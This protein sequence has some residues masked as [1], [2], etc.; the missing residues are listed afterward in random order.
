M[1]ERYPLIKFV[2]IFIAGMLIQSY[3]S[4]SLTYLILITVPLLLALI[5]FHYRGY[6]KGKYVLSFILP[7]FIGASL[8]GVDNSNKPVYPFAKDKITKANVYG[9]ITEMS[10][11]AK[12]K[13]TFTIV[14]DSVLIDDTLDE[15]AARLLCKVSDINTTA[16]KQ[17]YGRL[18][19]GNRVRVTGTIQKGRGERNPG[20]FNYREYLVRKGY[21][22][23]LSVYDTDNVKL[24]TTDTHTFA[25]TVFSI[26]KAIDE[27]I[28]KLYGDDAAPL[29]RSLLLADRSEL[30]YEVREHFVNAGVVHVLA[31]SGLHVGFIAFVLYV[32]TARFNVYVRYGLTI[33]GILA[34]L[35]LTGFH[36]SVFRASVMAIVYIA[37]L[38]SNRSTNGYNSLALAALII[39]IINPNELFE[40]G[41]QLSFSAV[42]A[43]LA[44]YPLFSKWIY[45]LGVKAKIIRWLLLF[46]A[47]SL[48]AQLGT[49]PFTLIY[50]N[51]LSLVSLAANVF[52]VPAVAAIV[53]LGIVTL[54]LSTVWMWLA[55]IYAVTNMLLIDAMLWLIKQAGTASFSHIPV[56][57]FSF[58]DTLVFYILLSL[59]LYCFAKFGSRA[60]KAA[61]A[62]LIIA[63]LFV[64]MSIDNRDILSGDKLSVLTIDVGQGDAQLIKFPGGKT[65]LID[66]GNANMFYDTGER[67]IIPL[68]KQLEIDRLDYAVI[69]NYKSDH[70]KGIYSLIENGYVDSLFIPEGNEELRSKLQEYGVHYGTTNIGRKEIANAGVYFLT[71][72][73]EEN[74]VLKLVYGST[75]FLFTSDIKTRDEA[76]LALRY[77][78]F[79]NANYIKAAA[80]GSRTSTSSLFLTA[81]KPEYA[82]ISC[83]YMNRFGH[84]DEE[85]IERLNDRNITIYR[86]DSEGAVLFHSDGERIEYSDWRN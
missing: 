84:P 57:N 20:E 60:A 70:Y 78:N 10:L 53:S 55:G 56:Y 6:A 82:I 2:I 12:N 59:L 46:M 1:I 38:L 24:L 17:L 72:G 13:I 83:G 54:A 73:G 47:V 34:F 48:A 26:R 42:L 68:L 9:T 39:L 43:I 30:S 32:L 44:L 7:L 19:V 52:V 36:A 27:R 23:L 31:V 37:A 3:F 76:D 75:S 16:R 40:P 14:T 8:L 49:L 85:V 69:T 58:Y 67:T 22:G 50:F 74:Q 21:S 80:H 5:L 77:G 65:M 11:L 62:V 45:Q 41:F 25:N 51:K 35:I 81:A 18:S 64:L 79:L 4:V 66:A 86:T 71:E 61:T 15:V 33:A 28:H 63:N 29:M